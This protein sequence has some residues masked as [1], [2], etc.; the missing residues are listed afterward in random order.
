MATVHPM[1]DLAHGEKMGNED[2]NPTALILGN[3]MVVSEIPYDEVIGMQ[4]YEGT[5]EFYCVL[6]SN[7]ILNMPADKVISLRNDLES[8]L[9]RVTNKEMELGYA[10]L[11]FSKVHEKLVVMCYFKERGVPQCQ[12]FS[13]STDGKMGRL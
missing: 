9:S 13:S 8:I 6:K 7:V 12:R 4:Q 10:E 11:L 5:N 3:R 1:T 2:E